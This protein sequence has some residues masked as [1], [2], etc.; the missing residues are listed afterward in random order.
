MVQPGIAD[1]ALLAPHRNAGN[2]LRKQGPAML[3]AAHLCP[4]RCDALCPS[5]HGPAWSALSSLLACRFLW[6]VCADIPIVSTAEEQCDPARQPAISF[7]T[8]DFA[9]VTYPF[10][11]GGLYIMSHRAANLPYKHEARCSHRTM[12]ACFSAFDGPEFS[13]A[14]GRLSMVQ[15]LLG[16]TCPS[17]IVLPF[18]FGG[19]VAANMSESRKGVP[20]TG[21]KAKGVPN[22]GRAAKG[23][24]KTGLG[25][26]GMPGRGRNAK[27]V[28][29]GPATGRN[30]KGVRRGPAKGRGAKGVR[31]QER[32]AD[33]EF[34]ASLLR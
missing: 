18:S 30:A 3:K 14:A 22:T 19:R 4:T 9:P 17:P 28:R 32:Q 25:A 34:L 21:L 26:K 12:T 8:T 27:G 23:V 11:A 15:Q 1:S 5:Q 16:S 10:A 6:R 2:A 29:K 33:P 13:V 20:N 31:T 7:R 24:P